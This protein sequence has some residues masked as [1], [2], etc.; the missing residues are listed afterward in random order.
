M[1][2]GRCEMTQFETEMSNDRRKWKSTYF[3]EIRQ[4]LSAAEDPAGS[5]NKVQFKEECRRCGR[6]MGIDESS[7]GEDWV[8]LLSASRKMDQ[9]SFSW[10]MK[11]IINTVLM[12]EKNGKMKEKLKRDNK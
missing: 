2:P 6:K 10:S 9:I 4:R 3:L 8:Y 5:R 12:A 7:E 11:V 1:G